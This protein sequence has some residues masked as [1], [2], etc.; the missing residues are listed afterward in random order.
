[1]RNVVKNIIL[2]NRYFDSLKLM[3]VS[4]QAASA[5][6]VEKI[7]VIMA[8]DL[9]K[10]IL[11]ETGLATEELDGAKPDDLVVAVSLKDET[12]L[13]SVLDFV[14]SEL[15]KP[16]LAKSAGQ[17]MPKTFESAVSMLPG[18]NLALISVPGNYAKREAKRALE[19]GLHVLLFSDNV[20]VE[21]ELE[22][23]TLAKSK[24]L[25]VM[26]PGCGTSIINS[27]PLAFAN[28]VKQG[29]IGIVAA[30]GTGIQEVSCLI[31]NE[32]SGISHA[33]GT[34]GRDLS[35]AIGGITM[36]QGIELLDADPNTKVIIL[37]SKP[38][39][40][41]QPSRWLKKRR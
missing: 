27:V 4:G 40:G 20:T 3:R 21:E 41:C 33:I 12:Y 29:P 1:M 7:S 23:K 35:D 11:N 31:S 10:Q 6:G 34:G 30:A 19:H 17:M 26:G 39:G 36:M 38:P 8:T 15:E 22:L 16:S 24:D 14:N 13:D 18:A 25:L 32:G 28:V 2:G 37:V 5:E 9:N